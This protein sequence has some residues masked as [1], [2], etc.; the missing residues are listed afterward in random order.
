MFGIVA[1]AAVA[2][3]DVEVA[4]RTEREM[5]A[6]VIRERLR[7]RRRRRPAPP[8][9]R[10]NRDAGS[11]TSGSAERRKRATTVSPER[12][13]KLTKNRPLAAFGRERQAE[14]PAL[15][16]GEQRPREDRGSRSASTVPLRTTRI[17]PACSTTNCTLRSSGSWTNATGAVKPEA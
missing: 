12:L 16:A 14:Q 7:D 17:R 4:V 8:N 11:A 15:A 2:E 1:G 9:R 13:V 6:V 10:S 5:P 3:A